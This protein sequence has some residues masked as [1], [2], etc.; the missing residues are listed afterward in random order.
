[1]TKWFTF[2]Y[3][4]MSYWKEACRKCGKIFPREQL[5]KSKECEGCRNIKAMDVIRAHRGMGFD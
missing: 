5:D 2:S 3:H 1:M 4:N